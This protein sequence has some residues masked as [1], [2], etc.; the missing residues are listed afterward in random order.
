MKTDA[1]YVMVRQDAVVRLLEVAADRWISNPELVIDEVRRFAGKII[2]GHPLIRAKTLRVEKEAHTK[3][4][5]VEREKL[6]AIEWSVD[7]AGH[8]DRKGFC[9]N[10][11]NH[12]EFGHA[13][14][15]WLAAVL[16]ESDGLRKGDSGD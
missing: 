11:M 4:T 9:P 3:Y 8:D 5:V 2:P 1:G 12:K 6:L 7:G 15:C 14:D 13:A 10:C 16:K